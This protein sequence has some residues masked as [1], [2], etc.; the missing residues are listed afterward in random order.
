MLAFYACLWVECEG[1][2]GVKKGRQAVF[3]HWLGLH[4]SRALHLQERQGQNE[5]WLV[6]GNV[7]SCVNMHKKC[8]RGPHSGHLTVRKPSMFFW[9]E[10]KTAINK[11][12]T[13]F[14]ELKQAFFKCVVSYYLGKV[15]DLLSF[16]GK[17]FCFPK[18]NFI[19]R[20]GSV[21]RKKNEMWVPK[22]A[23]E[24]LYLK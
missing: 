21:S 16:F 15:K 13:E 19:T 24:K 11:P 18:G 20:T 1:A 8:W 23:D 7:G 5:E 22:G 14:R 6:E 12:Q 17:K 10:K 9:R 4:S 2:T 3:S